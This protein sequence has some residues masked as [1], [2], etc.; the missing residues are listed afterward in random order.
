MCVFF[1][2]DLK[3]GFFQT[4]KNSLRK[5]SLRLNKKILKW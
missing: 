4:Y 2:E 5:E 3:E 1:V